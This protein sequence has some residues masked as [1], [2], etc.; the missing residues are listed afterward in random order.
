MSTAAATMIATLNANLRNFHARR[1]RTT[2][3]TAATMACVRESTGSEAR[4]SMPSRGPGPRKTLSIPAWGLDAALLR[5]V[6]ADGD[7]L[8]VLGGP[9]LDLR[10]LD[11]AAAALA[12]DHGRAG[13]PSAPS[14]GFRAVSEGSST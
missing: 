4:R 13:E 9:V 7:A 11:L 14:N 5:A 2:T 10:G 8:A 3:M 6:G 12:D 1:T